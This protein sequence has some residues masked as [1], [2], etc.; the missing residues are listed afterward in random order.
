MWYIS[1]QDKRFRLNDCRPK[2]SSILMGSSLLN[3]ECN[4]SATASELCDLTKTPLTRVRR[5]A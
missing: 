2:I 1:F 4:A 5:N 3:R